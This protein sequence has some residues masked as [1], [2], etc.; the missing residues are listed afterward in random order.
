MSSIILSNTFLSEFSV[1]SKLPQPQQAHECYQKLLV[2]RRSQDYLFL[3]IGKLLKLIRDNRYYEQLDYENF[4][5]FIASEEVGLSR[6]S[7]FLYI[8]VYEY[9][10]ERLELKA[11]YVGKINL[12]R[13]GMMIP[14]LKKIDDPKKEKEKIEE[15]SSLRQNDFLLK[16]RQ[17]RG[18]DKPR[19]YY[20]KDME[21]WI[22]EYYSN[23]THLAEL[24]NFEEYMSK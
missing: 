10:I 21:K 16:V 8:R 7:V 19:T 5:D 13:L 18:D 3:G 20:S 4:G 24:G 1:N 17:H 14:I 12:A 15:L 23:R 2:A 9:Y 22:V 11:D 6:E